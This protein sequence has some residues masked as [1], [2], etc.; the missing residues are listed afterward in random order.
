MK[1]VLLPALLAGALLVFPSVLPGL[2]AV[3]LQC[4]CADDALNHGD[5]VSCVAHLSRRLV[6][7]GDLDA[8]GR[9]EMI[10]KA[11]DSKI[12]DQPLA[13]PCGGLAYGTGVQ[14]DKEY[15]Q[16]GDRARIEGIA[17]NLSGTD[18][19]G[20]GGGHGDAYFLLLSITDVEGRWVHWEDV[21]V[22][23]FITV[24]RLRDG[25]IRRRS[26]EFD[27]VHFQS[28]QGLPDGTPLEP[29]RYFAFL[30]GGAGIPHRDPP[31]TGLPPTPSLGF[32]ARVLIVIE[33]QP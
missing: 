5:Y 27:L 1:V 24:S 28:E 7:S 23:P 17:W 10:R 13:G 16:I 21:P 4:L 26:V 14:A 18:V 3:S 32:R 15:Y 31:D 25:E 2:D 29:G 30:M 20:Y 11:A 9:A 6:A 33:A 19:Y 12:P 22:P 8:S